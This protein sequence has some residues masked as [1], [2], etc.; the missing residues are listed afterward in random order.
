MVY[1]TNLEHHAQ[2]LQMQLG[3]ACQVRRKTL[4]RIIRLN[5]A[6]LIFDCVT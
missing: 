1:F 5:F 3:G 2:I 4:Y 6:R